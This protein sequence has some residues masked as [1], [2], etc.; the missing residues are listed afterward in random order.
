MRDLTG[1]AQAAPPPQQGLLQ[2]RIWCV[3]FAEQADHPRPPGEP[4][5]VRTRTFTQPEELATF[6][7]TAARPPTELIGFEFSGAVLLARRSLGVI[8]IS[9]DLRPAE[10]DGLHYLGCV[11]DIAHLVRWERVYMFP[12]CF[13]HLMGDV[14]CLP[15]KLRDGRAFWAGALVLWCIC[16]TS[17]RAV[18]VEQP[19]TL[20]HHVLDVGAYP[21]VDVLETSTAA[22]GDGVSKVPPP[23]HA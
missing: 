5:D 2:T 4:L 1:S 16:I 19:D 21:G 13:Q 22:L 8:A 23:H 14:D 9:A 15:H 3:G 7:H 18:L 20:L 10:H 11:Q 12:P 17:T 6:L